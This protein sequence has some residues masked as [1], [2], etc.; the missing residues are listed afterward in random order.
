MRVVLLNN[1]K[2]PTTQ[3]IKLVVVLLFLLPVLGALYYFT[4]DYIASDRRHDATQEE[5]I[6]LRANQAT[7]DAN[8]RLLEASGILTQLDR[9]ARRYFGP[10]HEWPEGSPETHA[11]IM[12]WVSSS[13]NTSYLR[14]YHEL[15]AS[16][17]ALLKTL[18]ELTSRVDQ[19]GT[20]SNK[21]VASELKVTRLSKQ[22]ITQAIADAKA[23]ASSLD[24]LGAKYLAFKETQP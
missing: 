22:E 2:D 19:A 14:A 5:E 23:L 3:R 17:L 7:Y 21:S 1:K 4:A 15:D 12:E 8:E 13:D 24:S 6:S 10:N 16:R 20:G 11:S 9:D 18:E